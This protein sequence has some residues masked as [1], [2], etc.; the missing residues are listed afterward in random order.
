MLA[1]QRRLIAP[2]E[3]VHHVRSHRLAREQ[4]A[5][6]RIRL[7]VD[8]DDMLAVRDGRKRVL[9]AGFGDAGR[10]DD[11]LDAG[12]RKHRFGVGGDM[13]RTRLQR[14]AK[15]RGGELLGGPA[16]RRE[17]ATRTSDIEIGHRND[18]QTFR[19]PRLREKHRAELARADLADGDGLARGFAFEKEGG[20]VHGGSIAA[21]GRHQKG[22]RLRLPTARG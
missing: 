13:R 14:I 18:M 3:A 20:E 12:M 9:D 2:G 17:L 1:D 8:H 19:E 10:L 16:R 11:H 5:R 21:I 4:R 7:D 15:R 22:V 6:Q